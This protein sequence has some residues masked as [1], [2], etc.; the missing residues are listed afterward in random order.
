MESN[1]D[2]HERIL[3]LVNKYSNEMDRHISNFLAAHPTSNE[4]EA[5]DNFI[6]HKIATLVVGME[7]NKR[8]FDAFKKNI[9]S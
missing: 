1:F 2:A 8:E 3:E 6:L 7:A 5:K 9:K 4:S